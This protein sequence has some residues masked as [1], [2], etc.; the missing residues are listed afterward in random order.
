MDPR[1]SLKVYPRVDTVYKS[2][3]SLDF[4]TIHSNVYVNRKKVRLEEGFRWLLHGLIGFTVGVI[5]FYMTLVEEY[6]VDI[7][8]HYV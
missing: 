4:T 7:K 8:K 5:A 1:F 6:L 2:K 3:H